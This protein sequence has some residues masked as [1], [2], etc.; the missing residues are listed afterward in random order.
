MVARA[1]LARA[2]DFYC[3]HQILRSFPLITC[4]QSESRSPTAEEFGASLDF[5]TFPRMQI[6]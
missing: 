4:D 5:H 6:M 1:L 2:D 3:S